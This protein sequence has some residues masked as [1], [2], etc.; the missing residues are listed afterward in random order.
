MLT[1]SGPRVKRQLTTLSSILMHRSLVVDGDDAD[2]ADLVAALPRL[3]NITQTF[4]MM[5]PIATILQHEPN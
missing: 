3:D 1:L 2:V 5:R 4:Q